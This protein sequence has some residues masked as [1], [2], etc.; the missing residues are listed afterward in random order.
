MHALVVGDELQGELL[1]AEYAPVNDAGAITGPFIPL[2]DVTR[3]YTSK[4]PIRDSL[5]VDVPLGRYTVQFQ[6][7]VSHRIVSSTK[8][9]S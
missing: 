1:A 5:K 3:A 4:S 2:F 7:G 9:G 6:R 8:S